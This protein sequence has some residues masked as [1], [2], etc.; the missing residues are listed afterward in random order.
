[1]S[2]K[3]VSI[4]KLVGLSVLMICISSQIAFSKNVSPVFSSVSRISNIPNPAGETWLKNLWKSPTDYGIYSW[5]Q[6]S[7]A[8]FG[9]NKLSSFSDN[10]TVMSVKFFKHYSI[11]SSEAIRASVALDHDWIDPV[12][13][14]TLEV[15]IW[16][17]TA[18]DSDGWGKENPWI[19]EGRVTISQANYLLD[20]G[21]KNYM[22]IVN[23]QESD[24][25]TGK[26]LEQKK[27]NREVNIHF[28]NDEW[29]DVC[30]LKNIN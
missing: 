4:G 19:K 24:A 21:K 5:D 10:G 20:C 26:I 3:S 9:D 15:L 1:M 28:Q 12:V 27:L 30:D 23:T 6:K 22:V 18:D 7:Y 13:Y 16:K 14:Q 8:K 17:K 29:S 2:K 11:T 25:R